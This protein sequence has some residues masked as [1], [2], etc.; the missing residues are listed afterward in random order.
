VILP[1]GE[2]RRVV[3][4]RLWPSLSYY[5]RLF[6]SFTL[7]AGGLVFQMLTG[8]LWVG[9]AMIFIGNLFLV[10]SGYDNRVD[11][12]KFD[13]AAEWERAEVKKIDELIRLERRIKS[14]DRSVLDV[15]NFLGA[16][17]FLLLIA[18][19]VIV[20]FILDGMSR[21]L[22]IDAAALLLPHW[23]TGVRRVLTQPQ[24]MTKART[25]QQ[26]LDAARNRL[27]NHHV[28]LMMLLKGDE[29]R[30]PKDI[31]FK[32]DIQGH[33]PDFLGL[34]GQVV[35]NEVQ[36]SSYPYFYAVLVARRGFG[37]ARAKESYMAPGNITAELKN[38]GEVEVFVIRQT[39]TR[40]SG[41]HT[42]PIMATTIFQEAL[43]LAEGVA[44]RSS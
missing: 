16:L 5:P 21:I 4:F 29:A 24:L 43:S 41:Y 26:I 11:F 1:V 40:K 37:F 39:T 31:K 12:K 20:A 9:L 15:T 34:Y 22:A 2:D 18:S 3:V 27:G 6:I 42:K 13:P 36:G 23:V 8:S 32:V 7:I 17:V 35:L 14:W 28:D 30:L 33:H 44:R 38:Q 10:V 25:I 19:L